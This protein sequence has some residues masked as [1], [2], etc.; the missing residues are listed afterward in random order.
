[1]EQPEINLL[2]HPIALH[3]LTILR[4]KRSTLAEFRAACEQ[5]VP[6]ILY[7]A[8]KNCE[9]KPKTVVTPL[10]ETEGCVIRHEIVLIPILRA[11][12]AMLEPTLKF[13]LFARVD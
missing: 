9:V 12:L 6:C 5:V 2:Q 13:L 1:M 3:G 10:C 11:G 4:D 7:E 8:T